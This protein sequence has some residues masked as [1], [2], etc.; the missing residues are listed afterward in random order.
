M[1]ARYSP[2]FA[3]NII[4]RSLRAVIDPHPSDRE[5][6]KMWEHF[7]SRCA[8]CWKEVGLSTKDAQLDHLT[9]SKS[10]GLNHISNRVLACD[11]CN[12][13]EKRQTQW[14][15]FLRAKCLDDCE[16]AIRKT[17]IYQWRQTCEPVPEFLSPEKAKLIV[18]LIEDA[19]DAFDQALRSI[20]NL[21][22]EP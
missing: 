4:S 9:P 5:I 10:G 1:V 7:G 18:Q 20:R 12:A 11:V 19:T 14:L 21:R 17:R 15:E 13:K 16:F 3:K 22:D 2:S 6:D 8:Y